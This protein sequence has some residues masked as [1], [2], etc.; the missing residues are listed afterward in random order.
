[1]RIPPRIQFHTI[2]RC[3]LNCNFCAIKSE[4]K[5]PLS[6]LSLKIFKEYVKKCIAFGIREYELT[7]IVGEPML[8][9]CLMD[10]IKFLDQ[11]GVSMLFY[12][13]LILYGKIEEILEYERVEIN[14]SVYGNKKDFYKNTGCDYYNVFEKNLKKLLMY[15][16]KNELQHKIKLWFRCKGKNYN[17]YLTVNDIEKYNANGSTDWNK[18]LEDDII[19]E[20]YMP[21]RRGVCKFAIEDNCIFPNGDITICGWFDIDKQTIIGNINQQSLEEIYDSRG[22]YEHLLQQQL[23]CIYTGICKNCTIWQN[24]HFKSWL[25]EGEM[26]GNY[27]SDNWE[28]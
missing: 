21:G 8:D 18:M 14:V 22:K 13:N 11:Y 20:K 10:R 5:K 7:P 17:P 25:F 19:V 4:D 9:P 3:Q 23:K 24:K 15:V 6:L 2:N 26:N 27:V 16:R 12:T 28:M 1:M